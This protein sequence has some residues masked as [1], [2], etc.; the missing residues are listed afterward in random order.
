MS[1]QLFSDADAQVI[2]KE[3]DKVASNYL[4]N[5][6]TKNWQWILLKQA[7][8]TFLK[9]YEDNKL[10]EK[11][12]FN[13]KYR[14]LSENEKIIKKENIQSRQEY[15]QLVYKAALDFDKALSIYRES[16]PKSLLYTYTSKNKI[17]TFELPIET[18]ADF[19]TSE[20]RIRGLSYKFLT[21]VKGLVEKE[22]TDDKEQQKH[23]AQVTAAYR[24]V[25]ARL[26]RFY[27]KYGVG[28]RQGGLLMWKLNKEWN[29]AK[30]TNLGDVKEAYQRALM[31]KHKSDLD[32]L[33]NIDAG[34][35]KYY[36]HALIATFFNEGIANVTNKA[37]IIEED[38][39]FDTY[40]YSSKS[41]GA[42]L[43]SL[44]QYVKV[45]QFILKQNSQLTP[46]QINKELERMFPQDYARNKIVKTILND[47]T[48]D[49][50]EELLDP[51]KKISKI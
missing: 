40:Q 48:D 45:A 32:K 9:I 41:K 47:L 27:E 37:A 2:N 23:I 14:D 1:Q 30:V 15:F 20:G 24:G 12:S 35:P 10:V 42:S 3:S 25:E 28:Q 29:V 5:V 46:E 17:A 21:E 44:S 34:S 51:I 49:I 33:C 13:K 43:P 16:L 18:L 39:V 19:V 36:S 50:V 11:I 31:I 8:S 6:I 7:A 38:L 22:K 4:H 26:N